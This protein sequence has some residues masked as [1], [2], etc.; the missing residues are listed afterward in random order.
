MPKQH[1]SQTT[2]SAYLCMFLCTNQNNTRLLFQSLEST[3]WKRSHSTLASPWARQTEACEFPSSYPGELSAPHPLLRRSVGIAA[4]SPYPPLRTRCCQPH[5]KKR[6][7]CGEG[8][9]TF[10]IKPRDCFDSQIRFCSQTYVNGLIQNASL[11]VLSCPRME[12]WHNCR[13]QLCL[14]SGL[15]YQWERLMFFPGIPER[16]NGNWRWMREAKKNAPLLRTSVFC[17]VVSKTK[18]EATGSVCLL[19]FD[20]GSC[21]NWRWKWAHPTVTGAQHEVNLQLNESQFC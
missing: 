2:A 21:S 3:A 8:G 10:K 11:L 6:H 17:S 5:R 14:P 12:S 13:F 18:R 19:Q 7:L 4:T 20:F 16:N 1:I 9:K 15:L